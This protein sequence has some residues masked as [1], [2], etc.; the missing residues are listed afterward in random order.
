MV[1][2][3]RQTK[4]KVKKIIFPIGLILASLFLSFPLFSQSAGLVPCGGPDQEPPCQFC[5]LFVLFDNV[6][7]FLLLKIVPPVA[8]LMLVIAGLMFFTAMGDPN[9]VI[10][11]KDIV[12]WTLIG[13]III[14]GAWIIVNT[15]FLLI[16]VA[17]WT[18]LEKGWYKINCP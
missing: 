4:N 18:G 9:K 3:I 11:A 1:K 15:F 5:H 8:V 10:R 16:D 7:K 17:D 6:V 13:L 2:T 14:Y 12:Q